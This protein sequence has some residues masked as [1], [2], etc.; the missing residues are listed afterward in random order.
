V[1]LWAWVA[2]GG[3]AALLVGLVAWL[4]YRSTNYG[5]IRIDLGPVAGAVDIQVDGEPGHTA[6]QELRLPVGDHHLTVL[7]AGYEVEQRPFT[8]R[9][10]QNPDLQVTLRPKRL[11]QI[12]PKPP[13][14]R[15]PPPQDPPTK[16][17]VQPPAERPP[18]PPVVDPPPQVVDRGEQLHL[19]RLGEGILSVNF[20]ADSRT[21]LVGCGP[22]SRSR[23]IDLQTGQDVALPMYGDLSGIAIG[24]SEL[25]SGGDGNTT[26]PVRL[27][28]SDLKGNPRRV[29]LLADQLWNLWISPRGDRLVYA[30]P[31][32]DRLLD[33]LTGKEIK[34]WKP[35]EGDSAFSAFSTDGKL[36]LFRPN[37]R[38]RLA[39]DIVRSA[40]TGAEMRD[41]EAQKPTWFRG[42]Y[43]DGRKTAVWTAAPVGRN[44]QSFAV[45]GGR[46]I[47]KVNIGTV[48][49]K[50]SKLSPDGKRLAILNEDRYV[51]VWDFIS[52]KELCAFPAFKLDEL[53]PDFSFAISPD[54]RYA[55]AGGKPGWFYIWRL[56]QP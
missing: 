5:T 3:G 39:P 18:A 16:P 36:V 1:P 26:R 9:R 27:Q 34:R 15:E 31:G 35:A 24:R 55:V 48:A 4:A 12:D 38:D 17:P 41:L 11:A 13:A 40:D 25:I 30:S 56:P 46:E 44:V 43:P 23:L 22:P 45:D 37:P 20:T 6:G 47:G 2:A 42:M 8:V 21:V 29:I 49:V 52:G 10:G 50:T 33:T 14:P 51:R 54:N 28:V 7:D 32:G 53:R 19:L